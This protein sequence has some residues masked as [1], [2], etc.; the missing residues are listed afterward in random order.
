MQTRAGELN[1]ALQWHPDTAMPSLQFDSEGIHRAVL[2]VVTNAIDA[3]E[4]REQARVEVSTAILPDERLAQIIVADNGSGI[5]PDQL[6]K[7]F[8]LF[9][10][11]KG[12]RGTGLGLPVSQKI[13]KEHGGRILVETEEGQGSRFILEFP[14]V[15]ESAAAG[16]EVRETNVSGAAE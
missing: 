7:I 10:S 11:G 3:C 6:P 4:G 14:T 16:N 5:P 12:S 1:V 13:L 2:N 15:L 8:Q 9:V